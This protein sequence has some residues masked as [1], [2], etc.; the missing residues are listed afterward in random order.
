MTGGAPGGKGGA[1]VGWGRG[2][3]RGQ[4]PQLHAPTLHLGTP[5]GLPVP[6]WS[7]KL[8]VPGLFN[9]IEGVKAVSCH[10]HPGGWGIF[11]GLSGSEHRGLSCLFSRD[12]S[13]PTSPC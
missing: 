4:E 10:Y 8:S 13:T 7:D 3:I 2:S 12:H 6:P 11:W 5:L 1:R 9:K